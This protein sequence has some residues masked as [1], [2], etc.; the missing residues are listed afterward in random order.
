MLPLTAEEVSGQPLAH[1][2]ASFVAVI[3]LG[4]LMPATFLEFCRATAMAA[5]SS[6]KGSC[7]HPAISFLSLGGKSIRAPNVVFVAVIVKTCL[8]VSAIAMLKSKGIIG[9]L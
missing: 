7:R 2:P 5:L 8:S 6:A 9:R 4:S 1:G 3:F